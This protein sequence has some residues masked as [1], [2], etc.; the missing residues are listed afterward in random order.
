MRDE[1]QLQRLEVRLAENE[2]EILASQ[3]LR[4]KVFYEER[5]AKPTDEMAAEKRDFDHYD[6]L[7]DHLLVLDHT[8]G[9]GADAVV[10][11]YRLLRQSVANEHGGFYSADEYHIESMLNAVKETG[12]IMELGRSCVEAEYRTM[13]T[14]QLLW[15]GIAAYVFKYDI[16]LMFGCASFHGTDPDAFKDVLTYL[17]HNHLAPED[18]R[19]RAIA[20]RYEPMMRAE[21]DGIDQR[22]ALR[23]LP[24][25]IKGYLR[26]GGFVGDGA[27]VDHQFNTTDICIVLPTE[28]VTDRYYK[29]YERTARV[30]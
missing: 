16:K 24:P 25:L 28:K 18:M 13:P 7:C 11:T 26:L 21:I 2:T 9:A 5:G 27:V 22:Q 3:K 14:L 4:Y 19:P 17:H 15:Q 8:R 29:H 10:G 12:E 6:P 30:S 23:D 1:K 20:D